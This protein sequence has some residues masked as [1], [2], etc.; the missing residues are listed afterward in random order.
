[1]PE[2]LYDSK[3]HTMIYTPVEKLICR[4]AVPTIIITVVSSLYNIVDTYFISGLGTEAIAGVGIIFPLMNIINAIGLFFGQGAGN[5]ISRMLGSKN[6]EDASKMASIG[7][8]YSFFL[9]LFFITF[10]GMIFMPQLISLLGGT[11][12]IMPYAKDYTFY[13]LLGAPF[14]A[15]SLVLNCL[16]RFQGSAFVSMIGMISGAVTNVILDYIFIIVLEMGVKG[17]AMATLIGQ[18]LS[19]LLLLYGCYMKDNLRI[20]LKNLTFGMKYFKELFRGGF[21]S[22]IRNGMNSVSGIIVNV[23]A[24]QFGAAAI[25]AMSLELRII[26]L[27]WS[28]I[29]GL[30][31]GFQPVCGY[32]YGAENYARVKKGFWFCVKLSTLILAITSIFLY[33]KADTIIALFKVD[34]IEVIQ[35]SI[36][37]L[38]AASFVLPLLGWITMLGMMLQTMGRVVSA[39]LMSV[40]W[41][42]FLI[43]S[44]FLLIPLFGIE[45]LYYR[46]PLSLF[47]TFLL[48][49][50]L[51]ISAF[52][53]LSIPS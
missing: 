19:F 14:M 30:G 20:R 18:I 46:N 36:N 34:D 4:L 6:R 47:L 28:I 33:F 52:K 22:L 26:T 32:N 9:S 45:G 51:G 8:F 15:T 24:A 31:Q 12:E 48:S 21:P 23:I 39:S 2:T 29:G 10:M 25:A 27:P 35:L 17:A 37:L 16:L 49:I 13:I 40:A 43:P 3:Y 44:L 38:R 53:L 5:T 1:M 7:V 42:G 41:Q 11:P 50:P